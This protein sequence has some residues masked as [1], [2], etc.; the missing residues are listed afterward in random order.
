MVAGAVTVGTLPLTDLL[1][2]IETARINRMGKLQMEASRLH[3]SASATLHHSAYVPTP[4][5]IPTPMAD[6]G[7][8]TKRGLNISDM[9]RECPTCGHRWLDKYRKDECPKCLCK[10]STASKL[11]AA[12]GQPRTPGETS[13]FKQKPG[14]AM[15]SESGLCRHGG[16]HVWRFGRCR[17]CGLGEGAFA[18]EMRAVPGECERGGRHLFKFSNQCT[19]CGQY[20]FQFG[21]EKAARATPAHLQLGRTHNEAP[22][23]VVR[24]GGGSGS[25]AS[26]ASG[27]AMSQ[28]SSAPSL[29]LHRAPPSLASNASSAWIPAKLDLETYDEEDEEDVAPPPSSLRSPSPEYPV[30]AE[31]TATAEYPWRRTPSVSVSV[32]QYP[33]STLDHSQGGSSSGV[34]AALEHSM[35]LAQAYLSA[36]GTAVPSVVASDVVHEDSSLRLADERVAPTARG[37]SKR[38]VARATPRSQVPSPPVQVDGVKLT[39]WESVILA[40]DG[41]YAAA[42]ARLESSGAARPPPTTSATAPAPPTPVDTPT[43][44]SVH[45]VSRQWRLKPSDIGLERS[46]SETLVNRHGWDA[47]GVRRTCH[48]CAHRWLD[49]YAKDECPKC[50][51]PL[52]LPAWQLNRRLPGE[53]ATFKERPD[54]AMESTSGSCPHGGAHHWRFGRCTKCGRNEGKELEEET[55]H[56]RAVRY[57]E[58]RA[59]WIQLNRK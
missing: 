53:A 16:A 46:W 56:A 44:S 28:S 2:S 21:D 23:W 24:G 52:S 17:K 3:H 51:T 59:L 41:A 10:M 45:P 15:E 12:G 29:H 47:G 40:T 39:E 20:I 55:R 36:D 35:A 34:A 9:P 37:S 49:K 11:K 31:A 33:P 25:S 32:R 42:A 27:R 6:G 13:T 14:S 50:L 57:R 19:K 26:C 38:D 18:S 22:R 48:R 1:K 30:S 43:A 8:P 54:S 7:P 5:Y 4:P 58:D